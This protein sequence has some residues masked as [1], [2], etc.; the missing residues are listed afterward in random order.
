MRVILEVR[1]MGNNYSTALDVETRNWLDEDRNN[2]ARRTGI[3]DA[4]NT[5]LRSLNLEEIEE[6]EPIDPDYENRLEYSDEEV[7]R[8]AK[9]IWMADYPN[10]SGY[11]LSLTDGLRDHYR[12]RV[13][14]ILTALKGKNE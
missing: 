10:A 4:S 9:A 1:E 2:T 7:E 13:R 8:A 3:I 5:I 12:Q 11:W 6:T 14:T